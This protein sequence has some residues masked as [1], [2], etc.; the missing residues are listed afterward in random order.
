M[1]TAKLKRVPALVAEPARIEGNRIGTV[2][3]AQRGT[4][5]VDFPGN[6]RGPVVARIAATI[7]DAALSAAARDHQ[8]CVLTF[9]EGDAA[10]PILLALLRS[11]TPNLDAVLSPAPS[12]QTPRVARVDGKRV[13]IQGR[14]EIVLSCGESSLT[15]RADGTVVLRGVS[16]VTQA[17]RTNKIRG[18]KVQIN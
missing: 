17:R 11:A 3:E 5:K 13:E 8:E 4:V 6:A 14:E 10:R 1:S 9:E 18:G 12:L 16:V 2:V 15:L 7:D